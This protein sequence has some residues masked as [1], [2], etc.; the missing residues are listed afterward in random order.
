[1]L[2]PVVVWLMDVGLDGLVAV[3]VSVFVSVLGDS[4]TV[5]VTL[6]V[7]V[8]TGPPAVPVL[9]DVPVGSVEVALAS[10]TFVD[11]SVA[12]LETACFACLAAVLARP[13]PHAASTHAGATSNATAILY[14]SRH[15]SIG[16]LQTALVEN[17]RTCT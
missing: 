9:V 14:R 1:M 3:V 8:L 10:V 7:R 11:T 16:T 15:P 4:V 17:R 13:E 2:T 6:S 12:T 5:V